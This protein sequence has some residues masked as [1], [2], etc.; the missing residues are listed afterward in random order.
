MDIDVSL[1]DHG[2]IDST[3]LRERILGLDASAWEDALRQEAY[4]VHKQTES[5]LMIFTDGANWPNIEINKEAGWDLLADVALPV[6]HEILEK[7]Y[8]PGGTIIRAVA[9][10]LVAGGIIKTH[11]DVHPTFHFGHRIHIPITTNPRV[12]FMINGRPNRLQVGH[13][14]E[15]NNQ[16]QHSVMNKGAEDRITFIFDYIPPQKLEEMAKISQGQSREQ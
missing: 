11:T 9:A 14:Y 16:Q 7:F 15:I 5:V 4:D 12:R 8:P 10:K 3:A 13:A 6:M 2:E 1:R